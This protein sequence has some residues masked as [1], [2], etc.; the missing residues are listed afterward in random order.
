MRHLILIGCVLIKTRAPASV[1]TK[2]LRAL[3]PKRAVKAHH[4]LVAA[5][6]NGQANCSHI[7]DQ[8]GHS[9]PG[10]RWPL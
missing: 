9:L 4:H 5:R 7:T 6:R 1:F 2:G 10:V 8:V 3:Q